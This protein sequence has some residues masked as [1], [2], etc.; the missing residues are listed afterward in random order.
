MGHHEPVDVVLPARRPLAIVLSDDRGAV[1][2][3]VRHLLEGSPLFQEPGG[4][5]VTITMSVGVLHA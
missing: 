2:E 5:R 1:A 3:D 4:E